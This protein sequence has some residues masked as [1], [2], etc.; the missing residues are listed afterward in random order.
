MA[1][2]K[3]YFFCNVIK[4]YIFCFRSKMTRHL[5]SLIFDCLSFTEGLI[6]S[7][8]TTDREAPAFKRRSTTSVLPTSAALWRGV[9]PCY[10]KYQ[11]I[12]KTF[13]N[14]SHFEWRAGLSDI[15]LKGE[16]PRT[17]PA[18][19]AL[20]WF[21]RYRKVDLNIIL[22][23]NMPNLHNLYKSAQRNISQKNL[24]EMLNYSLPC[25]CSWARVD[26]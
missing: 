18:T 20:I 8:S 7:S 26:I 16:H 4:L 10:N 15:I 5:K 23:Q 13:S 11:T 14:S 2:I 6:T 1:A 19:F 12:F 25:I 21:T 24:E 3:S 9:S 17:I 22:Y